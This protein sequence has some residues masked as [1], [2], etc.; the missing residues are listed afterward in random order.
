[1]P[2]I[3]DATVSI[4]GTDYSSFVRSVQLNYG[5]EEIDDTVMGDDTRSAAGGL[6]EWGGTITFLAGEASGEPNND[7]F[8]QI[9][10]TVTVAV[11]RDS[12]ATAADNPEYSG[13]ALLTQENPVEGTVGDQQTFS[14]DFTSAGDLSRNTS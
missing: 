10:S 4:G 2:L 8:S 1:M 7:I 9:G 3:N 11:K 12:A 13:T 14:V 6:E 5:V